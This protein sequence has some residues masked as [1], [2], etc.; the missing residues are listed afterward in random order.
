MQIWGSIRPWLASDALI[1]GK[2]D[3]AVMSFSAQPLRNAL[4]FV[5]SP[6]P[7]TQPIGHT[8]HLANNL[9]PRPRAGVFVTGDSCPSSPRSGSA[10]VAF[11]IAEGGEGL[12]RVETGSTIYGGP[13][14]RSRMQERF[15][16][17]RISTS[18]PS[19]I[20]SVTPIAVQAG[21]GSDINSSLI[22]MNVLR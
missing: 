21:Y 4:K 8:W 3:I 17:A 9:L 12:H 1:A 2:A 22:F 6:A 13:S 20:S 5:S 16:M 15:A 19:V 7:I 10:S 14:C 11:P 18:V